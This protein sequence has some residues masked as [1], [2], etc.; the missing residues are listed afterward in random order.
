MPISIKISATLGLAMAPSAL[1]MK[2]GSIRIDFDTRRRQR[3]LLLAD[4]KLAAI[5]GPEQL[6][7]I[8][9]NQI[10]D[11]LLQRLP[12]IKRR[13]FADRLLGPVRIAAPKLGKASDQGNRIVRCLGFQRGHWGMRRLSRLCLCPYPRTARRRAA[14]PARQ[15]GIP[16]PPICT[17]VAAP[18]FVPGAMAAM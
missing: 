1:V 3:A 4:H 9:R 18:I 14:R 8:R 12:R 11:M 2:S 5:D 17:G 7:G 16:P 13:G 6:A 15:P 10:D